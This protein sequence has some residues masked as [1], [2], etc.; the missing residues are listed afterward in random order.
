MSHSELNEF[1][2]VFNN[3]DLSLSANTKYF[4]C[5]LFLIFCAMENEFLY[6]TF[7]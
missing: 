1:L 6:V 7:I 4:T 3:S 5:C 2:A